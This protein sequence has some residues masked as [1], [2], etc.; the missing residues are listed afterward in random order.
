[1]KKSSG[2]ENKRKRGRPVGA[3]GGRYHQFLCLLTEDER[4]M[5]REASKRHGKSQSDIIRDGLKAQLNLLKYK[6]SK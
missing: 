6:N 5:L 3:D 4:D 1:M 2:V